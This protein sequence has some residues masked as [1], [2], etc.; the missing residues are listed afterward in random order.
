MAQIV[1]GAV[2]A[3]IGSVF[4]D[5]MLGF[6]AGVT[7]A[8]I[9]FPQSQKSIPQGKLSDLRVTSAQYGIAL[10]LVWGNFRLGGNVIWA[11]DLVEHV[12]NTK[13]GKGVG[14]TP[15]NR[16]Y[17][18]TISMA[19]AIC[20][21]PF[22]NGIQTVD[23]IYAEN[24]KIYDRLDATVITPV[25]QLVIYSGA[26]TQVTDPYMTTKQ[27]TVPA[28]RGV[29]YVLLQDLDL[30]RWGNRPPA[31]TFVING[32]ST[33]S[34]TV[35][36][37][38]TD[39]F[40]LAGLTA[41]QFD[42]TAGSGVFVKGFVLSQRRAVAQQIQELL[43]AY[44]F[45]LVEIDGK[46]KIVKIGG[47][48]QITVPV[49][50]LGCY[51]QTA[52][53]QMMMNPAPN[54]N[55]F[56]GDNQ[57]IPPGGPRVTVTR[58]HDLELPQRLELSYFSQTALYNLVSRAAVRYI[59][60]HQ[61]KETLNFPLVFTETAARQV[62]ETLLYRE[63]VE[64]ESFVF[65]LPWKYIQFCPSDVF[66]LPVGPNQ[67]NVRIQK[68]NFGLPGPIQFTAVLDDLTILTQ[69]QTSDDP[70]VPTITNQIAGTTLILTSCNALQDADTLSSGFYFGAA[71]SAA[72]LWPGCVLYWS[73]DGGTTYQLLQS[74][75]DPL[76]YGT[77]NTTLAA[78]PAGVNTARWDTVSTVTVTITAGDD[79]PTTTTDADVLS[80]ANACLVGSEVI[81]FATATPTM[82]PNQYVLSRLL[83]GRRGTDANW[84][85]HGSSETFVMLQFG[86]LDRQN[87]DES[88][89]GKTLY[90]KAVTVDGT[91]AG[92][93]PQTL[94][95]SGNEWKNYAGCQAV[96]ARDVSNNLTIT[97]KRRTRSGGEMRDSHDVD[98]PASDTPESYDLEVMDSSVGTTVKRTF[99]NLS[100]PS[101]SYTAAQQVTDF[102]SAQNP[103]NVK[104][105]QN[106]RYGR[107]Y[108]Y[109]I[110]V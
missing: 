83:R 67:L 99:S 87:L 73:R 2:G 44:N 89:C 68:M 109:R 64:R 88:Y 85:G 45:E 69:G 78:P 84:S 103:V 29:A 72:G 55:T 23:Q 12:H 75:I 35:S 10:P 39:V 104:I 81:Q 6:S 46:L 22:P 34:P 48:S 52:A 40:G 5:P 37:I 43:R 20:A 98:L 50:D 24:I 101:A 60:S 110:S 105:Y 66:T 16:T 102:G 41:G 59:K 90:F 74:V 58:K 108:T 18:Y 62:V 94:V 1:L 97:W 80:G 95:I 71:G 32:G 91:L 42:V 25:T 28:Y 63:W 15:S 61:N 106:G 65:T 31:L 11:T 51:V 9:L 92:T 4:G 100:T 21:A 54:S 57:T 13:A 70:V 76:T 86:A 27:G 33:V 3:G 107:G 79:V 38:L 49:T 19:V 56:N 47:S 93:S 17:T 53:A 36:D 14:G 7:A 26:E 96:G 77:C 82:T 8:G 30:T